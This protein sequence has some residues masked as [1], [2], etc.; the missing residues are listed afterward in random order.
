MAPTPA[1]ASASA[2]RS[3]TTT[4]QP[5]GGGIG[6]AAQALAG[7]VNSAGS[8]ASPFGVTLQLKIV[9]QDEQKVVTYE[10]NRMDAV[11]RTYGPQGYFGLMLG[12]IDK[13][14]HFLQVDG[15]DPFFHKFSVV[16]T[17]M[18]DFASIGLQT[19]HVAL[20]Y[21][22]PGTGGAKHGEFVF[23]A[24]NSAQ[25]TWDVFEGQ[26]QRTDYSYTCTYT[27]DPESGWVG[28]SDSYTLP[29]VKTE[30]R[31]L[32]LDPHETLG[33]M[34]V[35]IQPGRIDANSVDRVE[36]SLNYHDDKG[37]STA[38]DFTVRPGGAAQVWKLRLSD[39]TQRTYSYTT[40][41]VLKDGTVFSAPAQTSSASAIFI[42][43]AFD[44]GIDVLIQPAFDAAHA[45]SAL[46][47]LN[48]ADITGPY[49][50][51]ATEF[52]QAV[53]G[54]VEPTRLHIPVIDASQ[55]IFDYRI[56]LITP[57]NGQLHGAT[58][59]TAEPLIVVGNTP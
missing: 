21:G 19:V 35:S 40:R 22:D 41:C 15:T 51:S 56:T 42:N 16:L 39:K 20:D 11:Q 9:H 52:L 17:P 48:Y 50:F 18:H 30:N 33:F 7:A 24:A 4:T 45:K 32:T 47:E 8:A 28:A 26:V 53:V 34:A 3:T 25:T 58:V 38:A 5:A 59:A 46:V 55:R 57:D 12:S 2:P 31:Q 13:S 6:Q 37:W 43:D 10:Y 54:S 27:F 23:N 36:V 49:R 29:R 14:K 44:G 1:A